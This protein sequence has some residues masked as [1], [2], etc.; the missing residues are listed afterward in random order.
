MSSH[1]LIIN[2]G[3]ST[4][5]YSFFEGEEKV[6]HVLY[7]KISTR[8]FQR[9]IGKKRAEKISAKVYENS[10]QD[11][12]A[13]KQVTSLKIHEE[14]MKIGFRY[15]H[16]GKS[17]KKD[18]RV[19]KSILKKLKNIDELAPLHNPYARALVEQSMKTFPQSKKVLFFDTSFHQTIPELHWR[20]A[21]PRALADKQGIRRYGFHGA[22]CSS[23]VRQLKQ[24]RILKKKLV[25]CHLGSGCSITAVKNGKSIQTS[26]GMT[27][28]EGLIMSSRSG[29]IDPGIIL[30]M[31]QKNKWSAKKTAEFL[32][33]ESGLK[34]LSGS[35]DMREVLKNSKKDNNAELAVAMFCQRASEYIAKYSVSLGG[36]DQVVFS[37]GIGENAPL[38]RKKICE[39]LRHLGVRLSEKKNK[40]AH[41]LQPLQKGFSKVKI[42]WVHADE[43]SEM[44]RR[45]LK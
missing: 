17:F 23:V 18:T 37:G 8:S 13:L 35:S 24:K 28:M 22:A 6:L 15:V 43:A 20:Y 7:E 33:K 16:G 42:T 30:L 27:P 39:E 3:S 21:I 1:Q 44:N 9:S 41:S 19:S 29:N 34:G 36:L 4:V 45:L 38:I 32:N 14:L 12:F 25:I 40:F 5:K 31:Q 26:M 11:L 10:L 2:A